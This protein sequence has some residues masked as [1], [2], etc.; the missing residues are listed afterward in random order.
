MSRGVVLTGADGT[1]WD[2]IAGP[3]VFAG[4]SPVLW[5]TVPATVSE[6]VAPLIPGSFVTSRRHRARDLV[7]PLTL[8]ADDTDEL[9]PTIAA[10][11]KALDPVIGPV[12]ILVTRSDGT[13]REITGYYTAGFDGISIAHCEGAEAKAV[14][15]VRCHEEPY[16]MDPAG[17]TVTVIPPPPVFSSGTTETNSTSTNTD[18]DTPVDGYVVGIAFNGDYPF[19]AVIPFSGEAG[20][21]VITT[22]D[23][24]GDV[25]AWPV[26]TIEG[27][28]S[29]VQATN[30][31][32]GE[33]WSWGA[34]LDAGK[35][36]TIDTRPGRRAVTLDGTSKFGVLEDGSTL[37]ALRPGSQTVAFRFDGATDG[38][39]SYQVAWTERYLTC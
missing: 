4:T 33:F 30:I 27:P 22:V 23:N 38:V 7:I 6:R 34:A 32:T 12:T 2:L 17:D 26:F 20:G 3:V 24:Q 39:S 1:V 29:A 18:S 19:S 8:A 16:W 36:L 11:A 25:A 15:A 31:T 13:Q 14:V 21:V 28:A 10:F 37:W 35:V 9:E 5:G